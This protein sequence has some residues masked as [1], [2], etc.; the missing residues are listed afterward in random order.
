MSKMSRSRTRWENQVR[1]NRKRRIFRMESLENRVLLTGGFELLKDINTAISLTGSSNPGNFAAVNGTIY[2]TSETPTTGFELWKTDGTEAGTMLVKDIEPGDG[3]SNPTSLTNLNGTLIFA[4]TT[5]LRGKELWKS[6]GTA[7]GTVMVYDIN[8]GVGSSNPD[9]FLV[10]GTALLFAATDIDHGR[11]LWGTTGNNELTILIKDIQPGTG[12]SN[13][14]SLFQTPFQINFA[15]NDGTT[16][17]ELWKTDATVAG[18]SLISDINPGL[19]SSNPANFTMVGSRMLFSAT[20]AATGSELWG[21]LIT[22][23]FLIKDIFPGA[24]GSYPSNFVD[25]SGRL[26]FAAN[27]GS[28][29]T[30]L[31]KS[32]STT[33]TTS[34]WANLISGSGGSYPTGLTNV[35][36]LLFFA[37]RNGSGV[38]LFKSSIFGTSM[39]KDIN[40]NG[41]SSSSPSSLINFNGTL[42]FAANDGL[43]GQELWKS[44]GSS[45]GTV[46]VADINPTGNSTPTGMKLLNNRLWFSANNGT[47]GAELWSAN[48]T[49]TA[50]VKDINAATDV[51]NPT[52]PLELNGRLLFSA[53]DASHGA[54]LWSTDG[55]TLGTEL[56]MDIYPGVNPSSPSQ[57][58]RIG[59]AAFFKASDANGPGLWKTD[60]TTAGTT[61]VR[62]FGRLDSLT[63]FNGNLVLSADDG[64]GLNV[65]LW[66][67]DGTAGGTSLLKEIYSSGS[68]GPSDFT[69]INGK[70]Y[71]VAFSS[72]SGRELWSTDGTTN[73]SQLVSDIFPGTG[74]STPRYLTNV[75]GTL[76]FSATG[77]SARGN[78]L[79]RSN[80]TTSGTTLVAD[81]FVG[82][83]SSTPKYL[84][85]ANGTLFF[86]A[87]TS[88]Q[89]RELWKSDGTFAGTNLV[90]DILPGA[91]SSNIGR[92]AKVEGTVFFRAND[93][94]HGYELWK[95]DG[96]STGTV[97]VSDVRLGSSSGMASTSPPTAVNGRLFFAAND[98]SGTQ[99]FSTD[100]SVGGTKVAVRDLGSLAVPFT[101]VNGKL[102]LVATNDTYGRELFSD[103]TVPLIASLSPNVASGIVPNGTSQ[104]EVNFSETV[105]APTS[106]FSLQ[107]AGLDGLL[108]TPDDNTIPLNLTTTPDSQVTLTFPNLA[109]GS[110]RLMVQGTTAGV[111]DIAGNRMDGDNNGSEGGN[112]IQDFVVDQPK[113]QLDTTLDTDGILISPFNGAA[114]ESYALAR[115]PDGKILV[116]GAA[117]NGT[118]IDFA[119]V[120]YLPD[121]TLDTTFDSD[122]RVL[123]SVGSGTDIGAAVSLQ[124]DG[125]I[126]VA[127]STFNGTN[128]DFAILR[129]NSN[130]SLDTSFDGD[131]KRVISVDFGNDFVVGIEALAD[132]KIL[133]GGYSSNSTDYDFALVK[134]NANGSVDASFGK[135]GMVT[136][137]IG[138]EN[139]KA[140]AMQVQ[141]DGKIVLA[142]SV[143]RS[144]A[145]DADFG[146]V[147][148]HSDGSLDTTFD[149]DG[150]QTVSLGA[151]LDEAY[152]LAI[153]TD[154]KIIAGGSSVQG[155]SLH[156]ASVRLNVDGAIDSAFGTDGTVVIPIAVSSVANAIAVQDDGKIVLGGGSITAASPDFTLARLLTNGSL[157]T[158]FDSDGTFVTALSSQTDLIKGL[159][160][161]PN[162]TILATGYANDGSNNNMAMIRLQPQGT[163]LTLFTPHG[164]A[165]DIDR[166]QQGVGQILRGPNLFHGAN[167]LAIDGS[168]FATAFGDSGSL[169][170]GGRTLV[171]NSRLYSQLNV[172]REITVPTA[173]SDDFSRQLEVFENPTSA[174]I[175]THVR[176]VTN[177]SSDSDTVVFATSDG[178]L[179]VEPSDWW[180]GTDDSNPIGGLPATI[181]LLRGPFIDGNMSLAVVGD[182]LEWTFDLTVPAGETRRLV[183]YS[184][185]GTTRQQ[186]IDSANALVGT[187]S[188]GGEA[189]S[190]LNSSELE[191]LANIHFNAP[192]TDI[193]L[194]TSSINENHLAGTPVATITT[195]DPNVELGD[196]FTYQL[197][198]GSG[199]ADNASFSL[200]GNALFALQPL[201]FETQSS[202]SIR[203]LSTDLYGVSTEK[204]FLLSIQDL[205]ETPTDLQLTNASVLEDIALDTSIG[206]F[207]TSDPDGADTFTYELVAGAGDDDNLHFS[208]VGNQLQT[209]SALN[210]EAQSSHSIR[211]RTTDQHGLF[212]EKNFTILVEDVNESPT[213]ILLS[214]SS[215]AENTLAH[216]TLG[217]LSTLDQ[218]LAESFTY[219]L[220]SGDGDSDNAL[221]SIVDDRLE[222]NTSVDFESRSSYSVRVRS[223]DHDG[224]SIESIFVIQV[225]DQPE[226]TSGNDNFV[227]TYTGSAPSGS[228][229]VT[230]SIGNGSPIPL[231]SFPLNQPV[232]LYGLGGTDNVKILGTSGEDTFE[233]NSLGL[234][235]NHGRLGLDSTETLVIAGGNGNDHYEFDADAMIG[236][237]TLDESMGG[238]DTLDFS[239]SVSA[240]SINL[241]LAAAQVVNPQLTLILKSASTF[242]NVVGGSGNDT[243]IGNGL[244]NTLHGESGNDSLQGASGN[245]TLVGGSGD[246]SL[247]GGVSN[248]L[249]LFAANEP[250]GADV[251]LDSSG[252]DRVSFESTQSDVAFD[253]SLASSQTVNPHLTLTLNAS[254]IENLI[255]GDGNDHL[256]GNNSANILVG[257]AGDDWLAGGIGNDTYAFDT[258]TPLGTDSLIDSVGVDTLSFAGSSMAI[259]VNLSLATPQEV[260]AHLSIQLDGAFENGTGG[261]GDDTLIGTGGSNSLTGGK[262]NDLLQGGLGND[263][264]LFDADDDL[265]SDTLADSGGVDSLHFGSTSADVQYDL[266]SGVQQ[267]VNSH[268]VLTLTLPEDFE[269][270][271]GGTGNDTLSGNGRNNSLTGGAGNDTLHGMSGIDSLTGGAGDDLLEGGSQDDIYLFD[272]DNPL[273][274]D[275]IDESVGGVDT[276][277]FS[278]TTSRS[279]NLTLASTDTQSLNSNHQLQLLSGSEVENAI[280]TA[281]SDTLSGNAL[282]NRLQGNAGNDILM[283]LDG[284]DVLVADV[285]DDILDGGLQN[286][287]YQFDT[288]PALGLGADTIQDA[289]GVDVLDFASVTTMGVTLDL[290][291]SSPQLINSRLTLTLTDPAGIEMVLGS[292]QA[293]SIQGNDLA[294]VLVGNGGNDQLNGGLDR[295]ILVGG[296]GL[297]HLNGGEDEDILIAGRTLSDASPFQLNQLLETWMSPTPVGT[298]ID[299]LRLG[300][301]SPT[302][303]LK[304][305]TSVLK[306]TGSVDV[307]TGEGGDDWFFR[308]VDDAIT[309][310]VAGDVVDLL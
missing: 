204:S 169:V 294:N 235:V 127:G 39:V 26:F 203:L 13:P 196:T 308:S 59:G 305:K 270:I 66:T 293:D 180:V 239:T 183:T 148:Y 247:N 116:V 10:S 56:I 195:V 298:R 29:G 143:Y 63:E 131:G 119:V 3:S 214:R 91:T 160:V 152:S 273:G 224:L 161:Q 67:S 225:L 303:S 6:D 107:S 4:A 300:V 111:T 166:D 123:T 31:W 46:P 210:F 68:S 98:S 165:L 86:V 290:S 157:D 70:L 110:Y 139:D 36:G 310:L 82:S 179:L 80:G 301:G 145:T 260:N 138:I 297:D 307:L 62:R 14:T 37:A 54:E 288:D 240:I 154:G 259:N 280:G 1:R 277:N 96:S 209:A 190:D 159:I 65:E 60:G 27:D 115:Q 208:I 223:T 97:L 106:A 207:S 90:K 2:F 132:G 189:V 19:A 49:T 255:G 215:L 117:S 133:V 306:D 88:A 128:Y 218:D 22:S 244:A 34:R 112:Y 285:G 137:G 282:S 74:S 281:L 84:T 256:T 64:T 243:L 142:G 186:A 184:V 193:L 173:G 69:N 105:F 113:V 53:Q 174:A 287:R 232:T 155:S 230:R 226:G 245:D 182:N 205:N 263:T 156:F 40:Q 253:L 102:L 265:G 104:I 77:S 201:D 249:Y 99:L 134:L 9:S 206:T 45:A 194:S 50:M 274:M 268:L 181:Q 304:A 248:D 170:D 93:G 250:L 11:E 236:T 57:F 296:I 130:G 23:N 55:T 125:K 122:G 228:V 216:S 299:Q 5:A 217:I 21:N 87:Q 120:R 79:W 162:G 32:D 295:D 276:L 202:Y 289:G 95:S 278:A 33:A 12:S 48:G 262:G 309:D 238:V 89:G 266:S 129:Y 126:L 38:E 241:G 246:D 257:G 149:G 191:T 136:T 75:N 264:Y 141:A 172:S 220:V 25:V 118:D 197:V 42:Y 146:F 192:P 233:W 108:G 41:Y 144:G 94:S 100:G 283:G 242:E 188:F 164:F 227:L 44:D 275:T 147:R 177:L 178:D 219:H 121:G 158:S 187:T 231:G 153:Q 212:Y 302:T 279:I 124:N 61:L 168:E 109:Q 28:S 251:I 52:S 81:I 284:D 73:G 140:A 221:F 58:A 101:T 175:L 234:T 271:V 237:V 176:L 167:R 163:T 72:A 35:N 78:E 83:T 71:F 114:N 18:T 199:D 150:K 269:N 151:G 76:L 24:G 20:S 16:G 200:L 171:T 51:S 286:D 92:L 17:I 43:T 30:E 267:T 258:S 135:N 198:A 291:T 254:V 8:P 222:N 292:A 85:N 185:I 47:N 252:V 211:V 229:S 15:A 7:A 103:V 272:A 213:S 261:D